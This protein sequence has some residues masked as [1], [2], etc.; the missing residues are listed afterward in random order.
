MKVIK[1]DNTMRFKGRRLQ[2]VG[3]AVVMAW[4][5]MTALPA[6]AGQPCEEQ[7]MSAA[8][9]RKGLDLAV[10]TVQA[11]DATGAKVAVIA[12]AGQDL[13]AY[14][15]RW[16]HLGFVYRDES[17]KVWRIVHKLNQCGTDRSELFRQGLA[18]FF[19]DNPHRYQA[20][21]VVLKPEVQTA[22]LPV[23]QDNLRIGMLHTPAY[24]MLAYPWATRYQQSN[25]WAIETMAY[26]MDPAVNS[27]DKA[28]AWL[29][30]KG[31]E[32]TTLNLDATTRLGARVT[33]A[34]VAFDDHPDAR[35]YSGKIDTITVDSVFQFLR[36]SGLGGEVIEVR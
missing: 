18:D 30:L 8:Q 5:V 26:A 6:Q 28:Q 16:S 35:R 13:S 3:F 31:Y 27:R 21:I 19:F 12:R 15:L 24:N 25:Q 2:S 33:R 22:L 7:N 34:N 20:A 10:R 32:P 14:H 9:L 1:T 4:A 36:A 23:L 17:T 11:L 29:R